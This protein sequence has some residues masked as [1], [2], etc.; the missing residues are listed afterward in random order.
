MAGDSIVAGAYYARAVE[1]F[2]ERDYCLSY[3][4]TLQGWAS[5]EAQARNVGRARYLYLESARI[6]HKVR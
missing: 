4:K 3:V 6:A 2:K 5:L 1:I